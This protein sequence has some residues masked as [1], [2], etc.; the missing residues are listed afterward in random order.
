MAHE[1]TD[2]DRRVA[3]RQRSSIAHTW[4]EITVKGTV[5]DRGEQGVKLASAVSL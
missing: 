3:L 2:T 1:S 4:L 5:E